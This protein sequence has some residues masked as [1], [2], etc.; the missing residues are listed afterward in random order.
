MPV[1]I[2]VKDKENMVKKIE[3]IYEDVTQL[4]EKLEKDME[5]KVLIEDTARVRSRLDKLEK[6]IFEEYSRECFLAAVHHNE[7]EVN[8][9]LQV[10]NRLYK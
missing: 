9:W 3:E 6:I 1:T 4:H 8:N 7:D 2:K 10:L 5:S